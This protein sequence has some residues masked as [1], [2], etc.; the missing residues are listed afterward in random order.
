MNEEMCNLID[1]FILLKLFY[2]VTTKDVIVR[3]DSGCG[4]NI[5]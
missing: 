2:K 3:C 4:G 5:Q 1:N